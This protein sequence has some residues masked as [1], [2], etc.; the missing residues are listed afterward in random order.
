MSLDYAVWEGSV[1]VVFELPLE[2]RTSSTQCPLKIHKSLPRMSYLGAHTR[3]VLEYF[4]MY[5]IEFSSQD[6]GDGVYF[7]ANQLLLPR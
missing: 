2:E 6:G 4:Q 7:V 1:Q 5:S 3:S